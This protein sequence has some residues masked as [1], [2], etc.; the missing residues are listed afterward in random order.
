M[1]TTTKAEELLNEY[2]NSLASIVGVIQRG[3]I[4]DTPTEDR[5]TKARN[6]LLSYIQELEKDRERAPRDSEIDYVYVAKLHFEKTAVDGPSKDRTLAALRSL[7]QRSGFIDA[8]R[9]TEST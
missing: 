1:S 5:R 6:A 9:N 4:P 8:A 7:C 3:G 2:T